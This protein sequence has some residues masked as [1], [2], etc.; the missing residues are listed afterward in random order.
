MMISFRLNRK[1]D[2]ELISLLS[3]YENN[4]MSEFIRGVLRGSLLTS[5]IN[6]D[7]VKDVFA[8]DTINDTDNNKFSNASNTDNDNINVEVRQINRKTD[9]NNSN[10][11]NNNCNKKESIKWNFPS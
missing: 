1:N 6:D 7:N 11:S 4:N 3:K 9:I 8:N 5:K 10:N 2:N